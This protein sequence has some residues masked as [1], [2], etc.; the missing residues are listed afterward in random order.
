[1]APSSDPDWAL[2]RGS[3]GRWVLDIEILLGFQNLVNSIENLEVDGLTQYRDYTGS[4]AYYSDTLFELKL[5]NTF[6]LYYFSIHVFSLFK[7]FLRKNISTKT[8]F[9]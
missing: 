3:S 8:L 4:Q 1:M 6:H 5:K 9:E 7:Y 2:P